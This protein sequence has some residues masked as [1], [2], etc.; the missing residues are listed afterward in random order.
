MV[1]DQTILKLVRQPPCKVEGKKKNKLVKKQSRSKYAY[2][3]CGRIRV[4]Q[5]FQLPL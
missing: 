4:P 1:N 5:L 3:E 2:S